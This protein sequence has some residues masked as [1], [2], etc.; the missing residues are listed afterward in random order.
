MPNKNKRIIEAHNFSSNHREQILKGKMCG[1]FHCLSIFLVTEIAEWV[2]DKTDGTAICPH[3]GIDSVIGESS[4]YPLTQEFLK[5][6]YGYW[7]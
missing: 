4:G 3:C 2:E 6:M 1:C 7:F 5:E